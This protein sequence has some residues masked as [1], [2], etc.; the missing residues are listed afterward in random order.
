MFCYILLFSVKTAGYVISL[1]DCALH[2]GLVKYVALL[3]GTY[4]KYFLYYY[5]EIRV[6]L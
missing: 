4:D 1:T 3:M 5:K 6:F 2:H